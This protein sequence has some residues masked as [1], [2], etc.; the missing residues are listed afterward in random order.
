MMK[1]LMVLVYVSVWLFRINSCESAQNIKT[2][3]TESFTIKRRIAKAN[4][5]INL[6]SDQEICFLNLSHSSE[7][8]NARITDSH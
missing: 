7:G 6:D 8:E 1:V 4:S 3:A 5:K 2:N